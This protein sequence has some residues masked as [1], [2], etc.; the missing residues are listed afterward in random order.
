MSFS[1][2]RPV[3]GRSLGDSGQW[4]VDN[5]QWTVDSCFVG[6]S[7]DTMIEEMTFAGNSNVSSG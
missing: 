2:R 3:S 6:M 5:G 1:R 7:G 4:T